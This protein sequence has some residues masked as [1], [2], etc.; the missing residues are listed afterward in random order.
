MKT[1]SLTM[2]AIRIKLT[3]VCN[4]SC[5]FCHEEG[6]M[7][8]IQEIYPDEDFFMC[9]KQIMEKTNTQR[10]MLTG[11]EPTTHPKLTD[12][13]YGLKKFSSEISITTNGVKKISL[14]EWQRFKE[15][16]L[17]KVIISIHDTIASDLQSLESVKRTLS[18][19]ENALA[20]QYQNIENVVS[21]GMYSRINIVAYGGFKK[22][23]DSVKKLL[24]LQKNSSPEIRLLNNMAQPFES[25]WVIKKII[26]KLGAFEVGKY[27]KAGSSNVTNNY[28]TP[29]GKILSVKL[30][31]PYYLDGICKNCLIQ[32]KCYEGFYGIRI[33]RIMGDYY[34]RL[35]IYKQSPDVLVPWKDFIQS[36]IITEIQ[37]GNAFI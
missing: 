18:W 36:S 23:Y 4:R 32:E 33:E 10:V 14:E 22:T 26:D 8:R 3:G 5:S 29:K 15:A 13:I 17:T 34:V 16:G 27:Q 28:I 6:G 12:I 2:P 19:A 9:I 20:N 35:C 37:K 11:G 7:K 31:F 25:Q 1:M 30:A 21:T 24:D